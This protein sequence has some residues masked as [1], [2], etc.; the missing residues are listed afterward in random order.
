MALPRYFRSIRARLAT[1]ILIAMA[2]LVVVLVY[3]EFEERNSDRERGDENLRLL[4][5][6]AA[7][8]ERARFDAAERL[9]VLALQA[10]TLRTA[11]LEPGSTEAFDR[12]TGSLFV[13]DQLLPGTSGFALWDTSGRTLCSSEAA[14]PGEFSVADSL[15]FRTAIERQNFATGGYELSPPDNEPSLGFGAPVRDPVFGSIIAYLSVGLSLAETDDLL[16]GTDLP[17]TGRLSLV[18]QNG[19]IIN[20]SDSSR[21]GQPTTRFRELFGSLVSFLDSDVVEADGRRAAAVRITDSDDAAVTAVVGADVDALVAP[22]GE[23]LFE[24]LWP[25]ALLTIVT[26]LAVWFLGERWVVRPVAG[27]VDATEAIAAGR[28]GARTPVHRGIAEFEKL[29]VAFNEMASTR[30]RA[31]HAKDEFLGLVSHEL[32][33]PITTVLGNAEIIRNRGDKLDPEMRQVALEDIHE[34]AIRLAAIIENLLS[35]AR[36][37]RGAELEAEPLALFRM[38]QT[39][40]EEEQ[41]RSPGRSINVRGDES[42]VAFAGEIYVEQVMQNLIANAVKYS[43]AKA[44]VDVHVSRDGGMALVIVADRGEGIDASE[45]QAIFEPFYR[46]SRT[47]ATAEGIGIGL[48]VCKRLIEALGGTI[49]VGDRQGGGCEFSFTL[50]LLPDDAAARVDAAELQPVRTTEPVAATLD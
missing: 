29:G 30:E 40:A 34:S 43:P 21:S 10:Q 50:P 38:A 18:D 32:K 12:C 3:Q 47:S 46:S 35:L 26:V 42:V 20:S 13:L 2:A 5:T 9:L 7:H 33:T 14:K 44:P 28:L 45:Q 36:L 49:W 31:S 22:L 19:I 1:L 23:A 16:A 17:E 37:E 15:W 39:A 8:A 25:I 6:F 24:E 4:A 41:R 11:A 27:L 48:S